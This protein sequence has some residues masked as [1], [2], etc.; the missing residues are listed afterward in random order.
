LK[1][2]NYN[3]EAFPGLEINTDQMSNDN[4]NGE[5][6]KEH[7]W[8]ARDKNEIQTHFLLEGQKKNVL[9]SKPKNWKTIHSSRN[10]EF[11]ALANKNNLKMVSA[12]TSVQKA[13][14]IKEK[15][16]D[17]LIP[18]LK[19]RTRLLNAVKSARKD[20]SESMERPQAQDN[21]LK[22]NS[23]CENKIKPDF[24]NMKWYDCRPR[25]VINRYYRKNFIL[26]CI[27]RGANNFMISSVTKHDH[28]KKSHSKELVDKKLYKIIFNV[29]KVKPLAKRL[30]NSK[31]RAYIVE[32]WFN[33]GNIDPQ[34]F[35]K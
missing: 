33:K 2:T 30:T 29:R 1:A 9:L 25:L 22:K 24:K 12:R 32:D 19:I 5:E 8:T 28:S 26:N 13:N 20:D 27:R 31:E 6:I 3:S 14:Q 23:M 18:R 17:S 11:K 16:N 4:F 7:G 10:S 35:E 21:K 15:W 34:L